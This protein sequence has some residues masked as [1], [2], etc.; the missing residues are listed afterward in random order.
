MSTSIFLARLLGPFFL[1]I[2]VGLLLNREGFKQTA[3]E[4]LAS[5]AMIYIAGISAFVAGLAIILTHNLWTA[6]WRVIITLFGWAGLIGG[7]VRIL[8]PEQVAAIGRGV[9]EQ[10]RL[11]AIAGIVIALI[12][13]VLGYYGFFG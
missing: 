1:V 10:T 11:M 4:F 12:G 9:L 5:R 3:N 6:D 13:F 7:A 2:G 8:A